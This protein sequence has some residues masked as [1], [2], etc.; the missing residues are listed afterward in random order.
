MGHTIRVRLSQAAQTA[1]LLA[2]EPARRDQTFEVLPADLPAL[3]SL[4]GARVSDDGE[5]Q[6]AATDNVTLAQRPT[7]GAQAISLVQAAL[8][9]AAE[10]NARKAAAEQA[11]KS[12]KAAE[13]AALVARLTAELA[14]AQLEPG[15]RL[16]NGRMYA[17][18]R[19][20][21]SGRWGLYPDTPVL[22]G[23]PLPALD[24]RVRRLVGE[25]IAAAKAATVAAEQKRLHRIAA[26]VLEHGTQSQRDRLAAGP[27]PLGLLP[28]EEAVRVA[29][30]CTVP[31]DAAKGLVE[32]ERLDQDDVAEACSESCSGCD[33]SYLAEEPEAI[34]A[35]EWAVV[36]G[37]RAALAAA[38]LPEGTIRRHKGQCDDPSCPSWPV[39]RIGVIVTV[40]LGDGLKVSREY[41]AL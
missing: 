25:R 17:V 6:V 1:A 19:K 4:P 20:D 27:G 22:L 15:V 37:I 13:Q 31:V 29:T 41:G 40:D 23:V 5:V 28:E 24:G 21:N 8:V 32:L 30:D 14:E 12:A 11:A 10:E 7:S 16:D 9:L 3:L 26:V 35:E 18:A 39:S 34:K 33:P 36:T 2:G 38:G